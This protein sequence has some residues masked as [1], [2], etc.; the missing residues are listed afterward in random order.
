MALWNHEESR[1]VSGHGQ[2]YVALADVVPGLEDVFG[3]LSITHVNPND[4]LHPAMSVDL[5]REDA[6]ALINILNNKF[7]LNWMQ[8]APPN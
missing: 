2:I 5:D 8:I 1:L 4:K 3:H 7:N 6:D